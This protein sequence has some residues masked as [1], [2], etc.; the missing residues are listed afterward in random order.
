MVVKD[1]TSDP[2]D[3][4]QV[5]VPFAELSAVVAKMEAAA[6]AV[7]AAWV[8]LGVSTAASASA[9]SGPA[10]GAVLASGNGVTL[11]ATAKF[12]ALGL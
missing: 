1:P 9:A 4:I 5:D 11:R 3:G 12:A 7:G 8:P 6:R 2:V 10:A